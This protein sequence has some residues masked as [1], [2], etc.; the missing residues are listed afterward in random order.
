MLLAMA[1]GCLLTAPALAIDLESLSNGD[2]SS[3]L[4]KA[5][6]QGIERAVGRLGTPD[7]FL[8]NPQVRIPHAPPPPLPSPSQ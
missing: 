2:A 3:G 1:A 5:L 8:K 6:G 4:R 7:G